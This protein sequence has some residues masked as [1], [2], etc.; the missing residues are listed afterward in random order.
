MEDKDEYRE[1]Y[2]IG[3]KYLLEGKYEKAYKEFTE[4]YDLN[5]GCSKNAEYRL[6]QMYYYGAYVEKDFDKAFHYFLDSGHPE[7][8]FFLGLMYYNGESVEKDYEKAYEYFEEI[9]EYN[10][11][12]YYMIGKMYCYG[13]YVEK[14]YDEARRIFFE[15]WERCKYK[16][17]K[18]MLE[19]I[20]Y[21]EDGIIPTDGLY[22]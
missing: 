15:L 8:M 10:M 9:A 6:G 17:A 16:K 4:L 19:M 2:K 22:Y 18:H 7:S 21:F 1:K 11:D 5:A 20:E 13:Y 12:A 14:D 3:E